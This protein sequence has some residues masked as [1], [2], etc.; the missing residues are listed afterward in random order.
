MVQTTFAVD[1]GPFS[2]TVGGLYATVYSDSDTMKAEKTRLK[3]WLPLAGN[4]VT[5][6]CRQLLLDQI[7]AKRSVEG[8]TPYADYFRTV[9]CCDNGDVKVHV[10]KPGESAPDWGPHAGEQR[11][12]SLDTEGA[13][14]RGEEPKLLQACVRTVCVGGGF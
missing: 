14:S 9:H 2:T 11:I 8:H 3:Q 1:L 4:K 5:A 10:L 13:G 6:D 7:A 12:V